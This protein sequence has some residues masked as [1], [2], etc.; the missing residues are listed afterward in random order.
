MGIRP[1]SLR[2]WSDRTTEPGP[3]HYGWAVRKQ[4]LPFRRPL[5]LIL[6]PST[7][8]ILM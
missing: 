3:E 1:R 2:R 6:E 7:P 8:L 4:T 5:C